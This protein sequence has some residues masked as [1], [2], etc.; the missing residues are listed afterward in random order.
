MTPNEL[1]A[2]W[3]ARAAEVERFAESAGRALRDCADDLEHALIDGSSE[4][5]SLTEAATRS[6]Y[7]PDS[8]GRMI[9][10]GVLQNVGT[11]ARPRV[12]IAELPT[13]PGRVHA[14]PKV[15]LR[16]GCAT[17]STAETAR[18]AIVGRIRRE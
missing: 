15:A 3:R 5:L 11:H 17:T 13:K 2:R 14:T 4:T 1:V 18:D 6:G 8:L 7:H 9:R 12:L 16:H 10:R